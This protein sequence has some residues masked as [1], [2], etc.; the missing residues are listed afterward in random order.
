VAKVIEQ[1]LERIESR[2][3][4]VAQQRKLEIIEQLRNELVTKEYLDLK[5]ESVRMQMD[6]RFTFF[7]YLLLLVILV[8]NKDAVGML[9][10]LLKLSH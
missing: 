3:I 4:E 1:S 8:V 5:L 2:S 10:D 7:F 6:K 9:V